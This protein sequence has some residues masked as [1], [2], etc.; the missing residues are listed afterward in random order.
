MLNKAI[1]IGNLGKDP[2]IKTLD[3]GISVAT[4]SVATSEMYKDR[5]GALQSKTEWHNVVLWRSLAEQAEKVLK[6]GRLVY[7]EGK[8]T[9][10]NY[11]DKDGNTRY[12]TEIAG[13]SFKVLDRKESSSN[14]KTTEEHHNDNMDDDGL[15]F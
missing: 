5:D 9:H 7:I 10:R 8:I 14:E 2:E 4:F 12:V 1:L 3:G 11:Q 13:E 15:P 6:K